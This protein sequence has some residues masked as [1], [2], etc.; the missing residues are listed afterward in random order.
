MDRVPRGAREGPA[1]A[2]PHRS[3][4]PAGCPDRARPARPRG[5]AARLP[6][7][8]PARPRRLRVPR[9]PS[10]IRALWSARARCGPPRRAASS[11]VL[12]LEVDDLVEGAEPGDD[13]L[14][15]VL[16]LARDPDGIA[17]DLRLGLGELIPDELRNPLRQLLR[18]AAPHADGLADLVPAGRLDLAPV[19]DLQRQPPPDRLGLEE[20]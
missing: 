17:L 2:P 10:T 20:V 15:L 19:E 13:L 18:Q 1:P 7:A 3:R 12:E 8:P 6:R 9:T 4:A 16:A 5:P 11:I 14:E